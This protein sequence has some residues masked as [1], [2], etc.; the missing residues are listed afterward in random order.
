[1][2]VRCLVMVTGA[3][4]WDD[5]AVMRRAFNAATRSTVSPV[6][7]SGH[8]PDGADAMAERL[9][10]AAKLDVIEVP[11]DWKNHGRSAG[12]RRNQLMVDLAATMAGCGV[13]VRCVAF[14]DLCGRPGCAPTQQLA[15]EVAGHFSHGTVHCLDRARKAGLDCSVHLPDRVLH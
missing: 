4:T 11:A 2:T 8:C 14:P 1:M 10:R 5:E 7:L 3:R 9:W 15:P 13:L 6:L 12:F